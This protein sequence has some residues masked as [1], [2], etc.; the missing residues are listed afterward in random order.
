[1]RFALR[2]RFTAVCGS[3]GARVCGAIVSA[4]ITAPS[5]VLECLNAGRFDDLIGMAENGWFEAKQSPY[6]FGGDRQ[7][8]NWLRT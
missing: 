6:V 4:M 5:E 1:M 3:V 8:W 7:S 2:V